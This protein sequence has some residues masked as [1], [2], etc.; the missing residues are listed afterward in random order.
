MSGDKSFNRYVLIP[1]AE[2]NVCS[3]HQAAQT[4]Q[5]TGKVVAN[6]ARGRASGLILRLQSIEIPSS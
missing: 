6:H 1:L 5:L 2:V 3:S 4:C